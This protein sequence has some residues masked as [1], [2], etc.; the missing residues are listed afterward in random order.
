MARLASKAARMSSS[1]T[2]G[3]RVLVRAWDHARIWSRSPSGMPSRSEMTWNGSGKASSSTTSQVP[4]PATRS[5][6]ASTCAC[7]F[8]RS[9]STRRMVKALATSFR[10]RVWSGGSRLRMARSPRP[11]ASSSNSASID[12]NICSRIS[13]RPPEMLASSTDI[14]GLR[15]RL[16]TSS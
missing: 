2:I 16:K 13:L 1:A 3:S 12:S 14:V 9:C 11:R 15:R 10:M 4:P 5:R 7:T 6:T 8:S